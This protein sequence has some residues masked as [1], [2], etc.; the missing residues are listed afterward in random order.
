MP[1]N[2]CL[3]LF[4]K[5]VNKQNDWEAPKLKIACGTSSQN[6]TIPAVYK[7]RDRHAAKCH[8]HLRNTTSVSEVP[9]HQ[10]VHAQMFCKFSV[11]R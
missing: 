3:S 2:V 1:G 8:C 11:I 4:T 10:A 6:L 5:A 7:C 9:N